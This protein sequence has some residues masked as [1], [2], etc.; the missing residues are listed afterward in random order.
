MH[1]RLPRVLTERQV[2]YL[3]CV[4]VEHTDDLS[5][6]NVNNLESNLN[7]KLVSIIK[8]YFKVAP[9]SN[10]FNINNGYCT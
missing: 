9:K 4:S 10:I 1:Q 8:I 3:V 5:G 2:G 6:D 7:I